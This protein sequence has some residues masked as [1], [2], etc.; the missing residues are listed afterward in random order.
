MK[1]TLFLGCTIPARSRHYELSARKIAHKL[2]IELV[3]IE[4]FIC[5]GFPVKSSDKRSA[6]IL[7]GYNLALAEKNNLDLC[8]L[9]SS[10]TSALTE[11]SHHLSE[12]EDQRAEVN[13]SLSRVG[14]KYE[15]RVKVRHFARVLYEEVGLDELKKHF[16]KSLEGL[17][18]ASHYGCHYIKPS[19]IYDNFDQVEDPHTLD[20]M[21]ALTGATVVDYVNKKRCCGGPVLA[22]DEKTSLAV[23]KEKLD[24]ILEAGAD[25][26][27]LVCPFCS[28]MYD[29]NQ[30]GIETQF[31]VTYNLPVLYLTQI[32]GLAMGLDRKEL[33]LN[34]NVV[35]TKEALAKY[36]GGE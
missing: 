18:I 17:R 11:A 5:C 24:D 35:K 12:H 8:S 32:L 33:G 30:K 6:L 9:C 3:D 1:Y 2:G 36:T 25:I 7:A 4:N 21:I 20:E 26:I 19:E 16:T 13:E 22:V 31:N 29:S 10:C 27:N 14:L 15:G 23:A 34:M 28:V